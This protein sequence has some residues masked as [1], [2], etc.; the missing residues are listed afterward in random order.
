MTRTRFSECFM[1][2]LS[3]VPMGMQRDSILSVNFD[4]TVSP[5]TWLPHMSMAL[6]EKSPT[7][8]MATTG[9]WACSIVSVTMVQQP[10]N[11]WST[12]SDHCS[13]DAWQFAMYRPFENLPT[14]P[15]AWPSCPWVLDISVTLWVNNVN[16]CIILRPYMSNS[17]YQCRHPA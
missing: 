13:R 7:M 15:M 2:L 4:R 5:F 17:R 12:L 11:M 1:F 8:D 6:M 16:L 10:R 3:Y 9:T 14:F